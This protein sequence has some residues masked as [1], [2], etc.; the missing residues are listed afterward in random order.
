M[1]AYS[2]TSIEQ[3]QQ[4]VRHD[5]LYTS[6]PISPDQLY[7]FAYNA[8][9]S[10]QRT[11][12]LQQL[13]N[14]LEEKVRM[15]TEEIERLSEQAQFAAFQAGL[16][17]MNSSVI[18]NIGNAVGGMGGLSWKLE[19]EL[20]AVQTISKGLNG[21]ELQCEETA[22]DSE[23]PENLRKAVMRHTEVVQSAS[24]ALQMIAEVRLQKIAETIAESVEYIKE[25]VTLQQ[26]AAKPDSHGT[27]FRLNSLVEDAETI[28]KDRFE[29]QGIKL[30]KQFDT[31][32]GEVQLPRNQLLQLLINLL[33]NSLEAIVQRKEQETT[34]PYTGEIEV[35]IERLGSDVLLLVS[36]NGIGCAMEHQEQLFTAGYTDKKQGSGLGLHSAANFV[37]S[38]GGTIDFQSAGREQGATVKVRLP[39]G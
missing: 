7:Q 29:Q 15:R 2:D 19:R 31:E 16:V 37:Q 20:K 4:D 27:F 5:L 9:V 36:D 6:K 30:E 1:T 18:H 26:A 39:T 35:S 11:D 8:C 34:V 23:M 17:E 12:A 22:A 24:D 33:K 10:W 38:T 14:E 13:Q 21:L 28:L 25:V 32:L 3:L